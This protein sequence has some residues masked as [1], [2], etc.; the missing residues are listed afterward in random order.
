MFLFSVIVFI[1]DVVIVIKIN[2]KDINNYILR[3]SNNIYNI[4]NN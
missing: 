2:F 4:N 3:I 1:V